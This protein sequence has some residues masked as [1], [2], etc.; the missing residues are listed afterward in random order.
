MV[1]ASHLTIPEE[2]A[3]GLTFGASQMKVTDDLDLEFLLKKQ[4]IS[5][6]ETANEYY[7]A[8]GRCCIRQCIGDEALP[9]DIYIIAANQ[10]YYRIDEMIGDL[11]PNCK[12]VYVQNDRTTRNT[13]DDQVAEYIFTGVKSDGATCFFSDIPESLVSRR[14]L[15]SMVKSEKFNNI[16]KEHGVAFFPG[17]R[18]R[19]NAGYF[20]KL[21][22]AC[23]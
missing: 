20:R 22:F 9:C 23:A 21:Q 10:R 11:L 18:G 2:A 17:G 12:I 7:Q 5:Q 14:H 15:N 19:G 1:L 13:L 8:I 3:I 4:D 16:L 6:G